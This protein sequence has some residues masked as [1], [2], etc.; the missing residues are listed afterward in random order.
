MHQS[1]DV[2]GQLEKLGLVQAGQE[3]QGSLFLAVGGEQVG[4]EVIG[5]LLLLSQG[6]G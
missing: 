6:E 1:S 5:N 2:M 4:A 3:N